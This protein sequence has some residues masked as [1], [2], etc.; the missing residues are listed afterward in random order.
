MP[1]Q[2]LHLDQLVPIP[3]SKVGLAVLGD[4]IIHSISP[5][6]HNAALSELSLHHGRFAHWKYDKIE[7]SPQRLSEA[8]PRLADFGYRGL[9]LT[10]PH[11]VDVL[12]L[13]QQTDPQAALMGAVN[14]L[15][16][17]DGNWKGYNTDGIGL[18]RA[19]KEAFG[20][21]LN[22]YRVMVLGA[23]G[24]SR[25]AVAQC[26]L[27]GC[28]HLAIY[29][30]SMGRAQKLIESLNEHGLAR[31]LQLL[32]QPCNPF[33]VRESN[34]LIINATSVGLCLEDP[35]PL[36]LSIFPPGTCVYDMVYNPPKTRLLKQARDLNLSYS[37]GLGMLIG[38]A[39]RSLEIWT[40]ENVSAD[41]MAE[42][43]HSF[44]N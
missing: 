7:V 4:P 12:P 36:N 44:K 25:A 3:P 6:M 41:A 38:Q 11:K 35:S 40:G 17:E 42:A 23:G 2:P 8:L 43:A 30:R 37:N 19:V 5:Q 9:N 32:S 21:G 33:G 39:V 28:E 18:S 13:L 16:W 34:I 26:L 20:R 15:S 27:E 29:N 31:E 24:A 22:E 10:I 1:E 14:T